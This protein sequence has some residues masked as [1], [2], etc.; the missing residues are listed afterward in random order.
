MPSTDSPPNSVPTGSAAALPVSTLLSS[1]SWPY[2]SVETS[3]PAKK[4][5]KRVP[6]A[7]KA[8][9]GSMSDPEP[10]NT[11]DVNEALG[12]R[13]TVGLFD[14]VRFPELHL[15]IRLSM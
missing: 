14:K 12:N 7:K 11:Q 5:K 9:L 10:E 15:D 3:K 13:A 1:A 8:S 2:G 4:G 6:A